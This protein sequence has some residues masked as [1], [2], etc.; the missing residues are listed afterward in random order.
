MDN[1]RSGNKPIIVKRSVSSILD[2]PSSITTFKGRI[3][4]VYS[5]I[6]PRYTCRTR[7][8]A[9]YLTPFFVKYAVTKGVTKPAVLPIPF[10]M[11]YNVPA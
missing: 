6:R 11:P 7:N 2:I 10:A 8:N 4:V 1:N 5:F 3:G 9:N